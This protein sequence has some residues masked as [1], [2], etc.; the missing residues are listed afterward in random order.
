MLKKKVP[1]I[2]EK[3]NTFITQQKEKVEFMSWID[4]SNAVSSSREAKRIEIHQGKQKKLRRRSLL[5]KTAE[6]NEIY[7]GK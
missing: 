3:V 4:F 5:S 1:L 6:W 2:Y 7:E